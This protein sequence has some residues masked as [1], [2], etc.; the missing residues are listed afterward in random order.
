[1]PAY[2]CEPTSRKASLV[3]FRPIMITM[4]AALMGTLLIAIGFGEGSNAAGRLA[5]PWSAGSFSVSC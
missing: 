1:M 4:T 5:L 3:R 2:G